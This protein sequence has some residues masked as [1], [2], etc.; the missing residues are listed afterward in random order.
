[1]D[2]LAERVGARP[3]TLHRVLRALAAEGLFAEVAP[4]TFEVT[5]I[6]ELLRDSDRSLRYVALMHGEQ[7]FDLFGDMLETVRTGVP[8]PIMRNGR[9]R[10]EELADDPEQSEVFNL[11]M[12][13]RAAPLAERAA[14][15]DWAD[16]S[17]VVDVG[18]GSGGVLLPLLQREPHLSGVLFDLPHVAEDGQRA[19]ASAGL[20][21]R[22]T[23]ES[24]SFFEQVPGAADAY[25]LSNILHDWDDAESIGILETCRAA[26][27]PDSRLVVLE[28][29]VPEGDDPHHAKVLDLLMLV[30]L[31]GRERTETEFRELLRG[32]GFELEQVVGDA[33]GALLARPD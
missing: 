31:G 13:G 21:D 14:A 5:G 1:V 19:I 25:L 27:R 9:S 7:I 3:D 16:I 29:I 24:G 15:L 4:R 20:A 17:T 28:N 23:V 11:A 18:G 32:G 10:W 30:V 2:E 8:V 6:G 33:P 26:A 22:C 12:R